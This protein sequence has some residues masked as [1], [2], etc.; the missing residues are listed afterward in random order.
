MF[1]THAAPDS[2]I[3]LTL[4]SMTRTNEEKIKLALKNGHAW[5]ERL[6]NS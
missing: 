5:N 2:A 4:H 1:A 6:R 3:E